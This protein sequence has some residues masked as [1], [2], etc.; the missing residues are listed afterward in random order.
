M[1]IIHIRLVVLM[2]TDAGEKLVASERRMTL[3]AACPFVLV[4]PGI[5]PEILQVVIER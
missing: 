3:L 4:P 5:D 2:T 1:L